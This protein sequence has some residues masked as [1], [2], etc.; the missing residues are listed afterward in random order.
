VKLLYQMT[1]FTYTT[2][3]EE[4]DE[5]IGSSADVIPGVL[6]RVV[7]ALAKIIKNNPERSPKVGCLFSCEGENRIYRRES[8]SRRADGPLWHDDAYTIVYDNT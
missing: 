4:A 2:R 8:V 7:Q 6:S 3:A 5:G 1:E